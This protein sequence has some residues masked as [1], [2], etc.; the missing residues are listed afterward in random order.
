MVLRNIGLVKSRVVMLNFRRANFQLFIELL[1]GSA[2]DI[3]KSWQLFKDTFLR[4][5]E[6][7]APQHE[8]SHRGGRKLV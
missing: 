2:R 1:D 6:F 8:K 5:Q 4:A 7:S 3:R